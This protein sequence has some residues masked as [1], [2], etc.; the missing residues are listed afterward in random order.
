[1]DRIH[2]TFLRHLL[3]GCILLI[4]PVSL[5]IRGG[6]TDAAGLRIWVISHSVYLFIW[7]SMIALLAWFAVKMA[8]EK[9]WISLLEKAGVRPELLEKE[10]GQKWYLSLFLKWAGCFRCL[11]YWYGMAGGFLLWVYPLPAWYGALY[12]ALIGASFTAAVAT[13]IVIK[14]YLLSDTED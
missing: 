8:E 14:R 11:A 4:V 7:I 5:S 6:Y 13:A 10:A 2:I 3:L 9:S 1:M 12:P